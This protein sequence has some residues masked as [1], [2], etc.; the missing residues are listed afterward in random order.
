M[1]RHS[2]FESGVKFVWWLANKICSKG[3]NRQY[4]MAV[5]G[6][7]YMRL[8]RNA[9]KEQRAGPSSTASRWAAASNVLSVVS[10]PPFGTIHQET[11]VPKKNE[12]TSIK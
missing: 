6:G 8:R 3:N 5:K 12:K 7:G 4:N 10:H 11:D 9:H 2:K 1:T